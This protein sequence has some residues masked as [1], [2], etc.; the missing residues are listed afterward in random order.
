MNRS[1]DREELRLTA[2]K[3]NHRYYIDQGQLMLLNKKGEK[4]DH[5]E[6]ILI[7]IFQMQSI[8]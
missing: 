2:A 5:C 4:K 1:F 8:K 7:I 6:L 3:E